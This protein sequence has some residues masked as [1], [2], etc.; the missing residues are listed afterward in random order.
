L[1]IYYLGNVMHPFRVF[2]VI[3]YYTSDCDSNDNNNTITYSSRVVSH[4]DIGWCSVVD[5]D[6]KRKKEN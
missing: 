1:I 6:L 3:Y 5:G 4:G 2:S